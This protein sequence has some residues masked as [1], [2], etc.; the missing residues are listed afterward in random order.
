M[1]P[2]ILLTGAAGYIGS[3]TWLVLA[4][5]GLRRAVPEML[6]RFSLTVA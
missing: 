3:H 1:K 2:T 4:Q 6:A 5:A